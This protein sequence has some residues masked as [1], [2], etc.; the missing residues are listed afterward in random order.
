MM[1]TATI[2]GTRYASADTIDSRHAV[3]LAPRAAMSHQIAPHATQTNGKVRT[4]NDEREDTA[5]ATQYTARVFV[6]IVIASAGRT[7]R[8]TA[9]GGRE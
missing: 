7:C 8:R 9:G 2:S 4:L 5:V 1:M 3:V 6:S